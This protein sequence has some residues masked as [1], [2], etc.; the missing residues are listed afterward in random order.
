MEGTEKRRNKIISTPKLRKKTLNKIN[1]NTPKYLHHSNSKAPP[2]MAWIDYL[3]Y[4]RVF[5]VIMEETE[6]WCGLIL[7]R[8]SCHPLL[9]LINFK[10]RQSVL[11]LFCNQIRIWRCTVI[12]C[13]TLR[14]TNQFA[15]D[16]M[17]LCFVCSTVHFHH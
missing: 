13:P 16:N 10:T 6:P 7:I 11:Q 3:S 1:M 12:F 14:S 5:L 8:F 15:L 4:Q 2:V 9:A 17:S